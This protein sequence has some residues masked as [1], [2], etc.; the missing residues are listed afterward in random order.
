MNEEQVKD[1]GSGRDHDRADHDK[2]PLLGRQV[3]VSA[4]YDPSLLFPVPRS[5]ARG[6]LPGSQFV[7]YGEDVWHAYELSWLRP[8]GM[9][10]MHTGTIRIPATSPAIIESK[11]L[12]LYLNSLNAQVFESDEAAKQQIEKDLSRVADAS[13][14]LRLH[15]VDDLQALAGV[16]L[17]GDCLDALEVTPLAA[18][19]AE[20][21][22]AKEGTDRVYTHL[23][24]SLCPVT[25]QPDWAT[26]IIESRGHSAQREGLLQY[27]LSYRDHQEFHE[28]CVERIFTDLR[29]ALSPDYLSVQALYTRRGG[30]DIC[31]FR[32]THP[33]PAPL[34]R[35]NRQ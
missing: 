19:D 10:V 7:G 31:P 30:L 2:G 4:N 12:K 18:P 13:V 11:S 15:A 3:G 21:L 29:A 14:S 24:R 9:P 6:T 22:V 26:V 8:G 33:A 20:L 16:Q 28:Q 34:M 5:N 1:P 17:T 27:L 32:C 25:S 35:I 23:M